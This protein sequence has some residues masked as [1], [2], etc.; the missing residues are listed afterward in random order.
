MTPTRSQQPDDN[1]SGGPLFEFVDVA[2]PVTDEERNRPRYG[3]PQ[4]KPEA[5]KPPSPEMGS[6]TDKPSS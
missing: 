3:R 4:R 2:H 6:S 5:A 1:P